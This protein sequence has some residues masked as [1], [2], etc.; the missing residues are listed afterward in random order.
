ML[1]SI[2][3]PSEHQALQNNLNKL[4]HWSSIWQMPFNLTKCEY[5]IVTNK[6][7]PFVYHYKLND[8]EIQRVPSAKYLSVTISSKLSW[9]TNI[10]KIIGC[11]NSAL[12]FFQRN[13]GQCNQ[14]IKIKCYET[15]IRPI[16]EYHM[17]IWSPHSQSTR[18]DSKESCQVRVQWLFRIFKCFSHVK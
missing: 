17:V 16:C 6:S 4:A 3:D 14:E 5:L 2:E 13:F 1:R 11:A 8:Y 7:S 12:F 9:S 18:N 10:S 15:C